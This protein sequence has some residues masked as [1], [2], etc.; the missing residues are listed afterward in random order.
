MATRRERCLGV[1]LVLLCLTGLLVGAQAPPTLAPELRREIDAMVGRVLSATG[2][3]SASVAIVQDGRLAYRRAYGDA[4]LKPRVPAQPE[5][6]YSIGSISKQFTA[7]AILML[8]EQGKLSLDDPVARFVP[9]L[10]RAPEITIRQLLSH[11]AG[12]QDYWPQD[13]VPP[14]MLQPVSA[15][16]ILERWA[17]KPLDF[18]PGTQWQYS[19][20]GYVI[21]GLIVE[22]AGGQPLFEFLREH[23]FTPLGM[24]S[25]M[26]ID[27]ERLTETD[28]TGYLRYGLGPPRV[29]PKEG[30]GWLFAAGELAMTAEDLAKWDLSLI[31]QTLLKPVSYREMESA[32]VLKNGIASNYGLG[33]SVRRE[34][35]HRSIAHA[36]AVSGFTAEN[37][38]FPDDRFAVAVLSNGDSGTAAAAIARKIVPLLFPEEDATKEE[39][40]ARRI[41]Q[42][43]QRGQID[44]ALFSD[45]A[46]FY[47]SEPALKDLAA[48]LKPLG[49]PQSLTQTARQERGGMTY[50]RFIV[51]FATKNLQIWQRTLPD[52][53]LEQYQVLAD[54]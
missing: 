30:K 17:R 39:A 26:N 41:F 35:S 1:G 10:T 33:V 22:R 13:Y 12:Y 2:V 5:M 4:G 20:T 51:K 6:R 23:I 45:N 16:Q 21:A 19:N 14:F 9:G 28:A 8:A 52:G 18:E 25:V 40:Q 43:L 27:Q 50:R 7:T 36:G 32:I 31:Q 44:R 15:D 37:V 38:V 11:T 29:A 54:E 53:K 48:G 42:G 49:T 46:N 3:P 47:F 24:S 34:S